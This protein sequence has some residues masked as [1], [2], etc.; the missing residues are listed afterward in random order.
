MLSDP[1]RALLALSSKDDDQYSEI[2]TKAADK[3]AEVSL[4]IKEYEDYLKEYEDDQQYHNS[5][6]REDPNTSVEEENNDFEVFSTDVDQTKLSQD[7]PPLD[8]TA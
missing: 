5:G 4:I 6:D 7:T 2:S 3:L 1:S 8:A